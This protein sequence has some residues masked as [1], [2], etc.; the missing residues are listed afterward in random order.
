MPVWQEHPEACGCVNEHVGPDS[1]TAV[2]I[3]VNETSE[4]KAI[5]AIRQKINYDFPLWELMDAERKLNKK[6]LESIKKL[7]DLL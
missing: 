3:L 5:R 2:L 7:E 6:E 1:R 4:T